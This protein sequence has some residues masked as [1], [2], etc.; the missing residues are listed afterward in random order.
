M[1]EAVREACDA[2]IDKHVRV[3]TEMECLTVHKDPVQCEK[4]V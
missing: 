1:T 2:V 4:H 3:G